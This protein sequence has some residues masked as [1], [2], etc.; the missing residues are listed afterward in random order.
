MKW[1]NNVDKQYIFITTY[2]K[3]TKK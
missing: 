3:K 2:V 1:Q